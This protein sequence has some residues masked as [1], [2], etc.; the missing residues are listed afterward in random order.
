MVEKAP[1]LDPHDVDPEN[2][3]RVN[4][5]LQPARLGRGLHHE[6]H[7]AYSGADH[8]QAQDRRAADRPG[9]DRRRRLPRDR[10]DA[11]HLSPLAPAVRRH[12][13]RGSQTANSAGEGERPAQKA[14]GRS[15]VGE[16]NA[17]GS[18]RGKLLSPVRRRR[19]VT[20]LQERYRASERF[21]CRVVGQHRSTQRHGGKAIDLEEAKL[22]QRLREI[23]ADHIRW[24]R[25]MAYRL[26]RRE[27]WTVNHKRGQRLWREEGLQRPTPRKRKRA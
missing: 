16:G 17:Q 10:G 24:G 8:P 18:R 13:G 27:G 14:S 11:A 22:R 4:E 9:Q 25:R 3:S 7:Q 21:V 26:L 15:R 2:R 6:T 20:V 1:Q 12:A 5:S 23:A 19:A